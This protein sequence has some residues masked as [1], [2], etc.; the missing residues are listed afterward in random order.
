[1]KILISTDTYYPNVNGASYFTQRLAFYLEQK[2]HDVLVIAPSR[3]FGHES[4]E[5]NG[6]TVFGIRSFPVPFYKKFRF[7]LPIRIKKS[8]EEK[9][10]EFS[11]DVVHLQGHFFI[12][13]IIFN[14]G[15]KLGIPIIGTNHFMP[16]NLV[17]YSPFTEKFTDSVVRLEW[18]KFKKVFENVD[19]ATTPTETAAEYLKKIGLKKPVMAVSCGID[20]TKFRPGGNPDLLKKKY[21]IPVGVPVL[22]YVGRLDKEKN[23]DFILRSISSEKINCHFVIVGI[24]DESENLKKLAKILRLEKSVTF[25]GFVPNENLPQIYDVGDC[26]VNASEAELQSIVTMEAMA[27]GLPVVAVRAMALPE[28]VHHGVNGYTF[29]SGDVAD[30]KRHLVE[31]LSNKE[32]KNKMSQ[33]SLEIIKDHDINKTIEKFEM[34]Y[35]GA[36]EFYKISGKK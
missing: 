14:A 2:G 24:G 4:F 10:K 25:T 17:P 3:K 28:L 19:V 7:A 36:I 6:V 23:I 15:K 18:N 35:G 8:I 13:K 33:A 29:E 1:M 20:L 9:I 12:S 16:E 11:P 34:I 26:F 27:S 30:F 31:I 21:G 5:H 32:L 22:L